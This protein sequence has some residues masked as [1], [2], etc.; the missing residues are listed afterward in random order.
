MVRAVALLSLSLACSPP[1]TTTPPRPRPTAAPRPS[2]A[3]GDACAPDRASPQST[4]G[5]GQLCMPMPGGY[6]TAACGATGT[7][8]P[9]GSVCLPTGRAGELC[10]RACA[11]DADCRGGEGYVCDPARHACTLPFF[12]APALA[13]CDAP[14]PPDGRFTPPVALSTR[15]MPGVYQFEPAAVLTARG[16]LVTLFTSG[17]PI[18]GSSFLG[19]A[20]VPAGGGAPVVDQVIATS[21]KMHFDPWLAVGRDGT[22]H[23]VWLGHDGGG[24]DLDAEIGYARSTDGGATW[25]APV[26][27]HDPADCPPGTPF[28]LDKP[29][30]ALGPAPGTPRVEAVRVFYS[31]EK[32]LRMRS[33]TDGG[34]S[35]GAAVSVIDGA[36][37]DVAIDR[38]GRVHV[39][40]SLAAPRGAGAWGSPEASIAYTSSTDG[41]RFAPPI[42]VSAA[43]ESIPF[44]FA[45]PTLA[46]DD[47][48]SAVHVAY[49]AGTPDGRWDIQLASSRDAGRRWTRTRVNDDPPCANHMVPNLALDGGGRLHLTWYEDRGGGGHLAYTTCAAGR[50][51]RARRV[52]PD[53]AAYELVRHSSKWLG[54][55]ESLL[56]DER[57]RAVHAVWTQVVDEGGRP[58]AR[59]HHATGPLAR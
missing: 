27:V 46:V 20:R 22:L 43:G 19:S 35:F 30:I 39:V 11:G 29:M 23:A 5:A 45:N 33:S 37:G 41:A 51:A 13:T 8:C 16:D 32:G 6:C 58:I 25:S 26:A 7:A 40:V 42:T 59:I 17:G 55:Y 36:Y 12:A 2:G 52:A 47:R 34:A 57:R 14:A 1:A 50:C 24:V 28:C 44:F 4:C 56:I 31:G 9:A 18:F 54:E 53:M 38:R 21:K 15:A 48:R 3:I 49:A 10:A